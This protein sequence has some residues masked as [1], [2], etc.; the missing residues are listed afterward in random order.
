MQIIGIKGKNKRADTIRHAKKERRPPNLSRS[1]Q[2][3]LGKFQGKM[4]REGIGIH[5]S[6]LFNSHVLFNLS[7]TKVSIDF[8]EDFEINLITRHIQHIICSESFAQVLGVKTAR[9]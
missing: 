5:P 4:S 9:L 8:V 3:T 7:E 2:K 6:I 1:E